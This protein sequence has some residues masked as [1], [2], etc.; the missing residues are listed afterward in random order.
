VLSSVVLKGRVRDERTERRC[1]VRSLWG[2]AG[3]KAGS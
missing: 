2:P 3:G 1:N